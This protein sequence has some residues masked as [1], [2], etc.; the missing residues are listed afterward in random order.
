MSTKKNNEV[1]SN[2]MH[3]CEINCKDAAVFNVLDLGDEKTYMD[4]TH[5]C[6]HHLVGMIG[7]NTLHEV[8]RL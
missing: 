5:C 1:L 6:E 4:Y 7:E 8:R 2:I 3:C